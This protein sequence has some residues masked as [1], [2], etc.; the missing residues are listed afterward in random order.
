MNYQE[1]IA[2][3]Y[4][5][6]PI[7][8]RVGVTAYKEDL[9]NI[10]QLC[11][12][13]GHPEKKIRSI[14]IAGTNGKGSNCHIIASV[15]QEAGYKVGLHTSPHLV[16]FRERSR[17]DGKMMT[18][19]FVVEFVEKNQ[20]RIEQLQAS[21][22]EVSVAMAF[23]YFAEHK[24]DI[25]V[26]ETGLG[27]RLDSTNVL[28]PELSIITNIGKDH[29][30]IL[31]ESLEEIAREKAGIIKVGIPV[32]IGEEREHIQ[33]LIAQVAEKKK[34]PF[35]LAREQ[36]YKTDL[37]GRYQQKNINTAV[38]ALEILK[39]QS[40]KISSDSI[41]SGL[42]KVVKNTQLRGRWEILNESPYTV[43][44]T[45][46]NL[47]GIKEV[48]LQ[49]SETKYEKLH[50]VL[51][52]V[53]DK[54]VEEILALFPREAHYYFT[55]PDVPRKLK[56]EDLKSR[57]PKFLEKVSYHNEVKI[58]YKQAQKYA[59]SQDMIYVGGSTFVVAELLLE[60]NQV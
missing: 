34:A 51:G 47:A 40:W 49:I 41:I 26:V 58:A 59:A 3:L 39:E 16:D 32:V 48:L 37:K 36:K 35:F 19:K 14:H 22:F 7:F 10:E 18:Q 4:A 27:G 57:V 24:V 2:W 33:R 42:S 21:F 5:R 13:L 52:F 17:I 38:T 11:S 54:K 12:F 46:H 55:A 31:G 60:K 43:A 30:A 20:K 53:N 8:Q 50:F 23:S 25:A 9:G 28:L 1:T 29:T 6:L 56:V 15:L 45:A 44:D